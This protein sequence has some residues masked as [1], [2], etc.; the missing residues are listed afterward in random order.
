MQQKIA[1]H[2]QTGLFKPKQRSVA[3]AFDLS[4]AWLAY[5]LVPNHYPPMAKPR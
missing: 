4:L 3:L 5:K 1:W 2:Q